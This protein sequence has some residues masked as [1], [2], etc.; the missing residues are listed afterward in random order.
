MK[1][2]MSEP[3]SYEL[4]AYEAVIASSWAQTHKKTVPMTLILLA[5]HERPAWSSTIKSAIAELT[6]GNLQFD[7]QSL[8][9][10][11]RRLEEHNLL[12][13]QEAVP[14]TGAKRKVYALT[15]SGDRILRHQVAATMSY[16]RHPA[17]LALGSGG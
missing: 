4:T 9:L 12:H 7:D 5:L 15:R 6:G 1:T 10:A 8:H 16:A 13:R 3:A 14:G 11:L 2:S 17:F